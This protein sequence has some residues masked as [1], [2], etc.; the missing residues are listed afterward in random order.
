MSGLP[1]EATELR[2]SWI[3]SFVPHPDISALPNHLVS[4]VALRLNKALN[5]VDSI[6]TPTVS[7]P[8]C[9]I[10]PD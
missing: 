7:T 4:A 2:T 10:V 6:R 9:V 1:S 3:G 8:R 5:F